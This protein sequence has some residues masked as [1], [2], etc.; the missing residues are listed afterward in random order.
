MEKHIEHLKVYHFFKYCKI[1]SKSYSLGYE[2]AP[3]PQEA[4]HNLT[5]RNLATDRERETAVI[6]WNEA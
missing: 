6:W 3:T 2:V 4:Y 5:S 1:N